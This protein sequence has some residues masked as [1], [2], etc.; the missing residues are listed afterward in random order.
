MLNFFIQL[1]DF[2]DTDTGFNRLTWFDEL[3]Q[4]FF[5]LFFF[6]IKFFRL[7]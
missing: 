1:S 4:N 7:L 5:L 6:L 2:H 3:T